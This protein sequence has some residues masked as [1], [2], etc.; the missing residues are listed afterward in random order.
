M[1]HLRKTFN[2]PS[3]ADHVSR[4]CRSLPYANLR[5]ECKS[6]Q[7]DHGGS[8]NGVAQSNFVL[9]HYVTH[10]SS[11]SDDDKGFWLTIRPTG[12][13]VKETDDSGRGLFCCCPKRHGLEQ[14]S[15]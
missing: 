9:H 3:D 8:Q 13:E 15:R 11:G 12:F 5:K 10:R 7:A 1:G 4:H 6:E 2:L 14:N